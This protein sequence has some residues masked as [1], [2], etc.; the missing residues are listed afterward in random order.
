MRTFLA[1]LTITLGIITIHAQTYTVP[2]DPTN[3]MIIPPPSQAWQ[4]AKYGEYPVNRSTGVPAIS[5]PIHEIKVGPLSIPIGLNYHA[6]GIKVDEKASWV[7]LGWNLSAGGMISRVV[8]GHP[9]EHENG[10][11]NRE[12]PGS[13]DP[14]TIDDYEDLAR[15]NEGFYDTEPDIF[16]YNFN[17][18]SGRFFYKDVNTIITQPSSDLLIEYELAEI[19]GICAFTITTPDGIIYDF[20]LSETVTYEP[21]ID[22]FFTAGQDSWTASSVWYLTKI[23]SLITGESI[24]FTYDPLSVT[25]S[26]PFPVQSRTIKLIPGSP[27]SITDYGLDDELTYPNAYSGLRYLKEIQYSNGKVVFNSDSYRGNYDSK[28]PRLTSIDIYGFENELKRTFKLDNDQFFTSSGGSSSR[29][30]YRL[31]LDAVWMESSSINQDRTYAFTYLTSGAQALPPRYDT[32]QDY[33]GYHNGEP[34]QSLIPETPYPSYGFTFGSGNDLSSSEEH[35]K[36]GILEKITYPTKGYTLFDFEAN[37]IREDNSNVTVGGLRVKSIKNYNATGELATQKHFIYEDV[38]ATGESSGVYNAP[39]TPNPYTYL[40]SVEIR[41]KELDSNDQCD[42]FTDTYVSV[43]AKPKNMLGFPSGDLVT[44]KYVTVIHEESQSEYGKSVYEYDTYADDIIWNRSPYTI[45]RSELRG[46]LKNETHFDDNGDEVRSIGYDYTTTEVESIKG[47]KIGKIFDFPLGTDCWV[48]SF[49]CSCTE[50]TRLNSVLGMYLHNSYWERSYWK[51]LDSKTEVVYGTNGETT[52]TITEYSYDGTGHQ[53]LTSQSIT[54]SDGR[55]SKLKNKYPLDYAEGSRSAILNSMIL[56]NY[57]APSIEQIFSLDGKVLQA[58][59]TQY[60]HDPSN[61]L[62]L[63]FKQYT[64]ETDTPISS[65][66]ESSDGSSFSSYE[67]WGTYK[68]F[69]FK[70]NL[71]S[72]SLTDNIST[73]YIWGYNNS[74]PVAK[75]SNAEI[76]YTGETNKQVSTQNYSDVTSWTNLG[77]SL[78]LDRDQSISITISVTFEEEGEGDDV[79]CGVRLKHPDGTTDVFSDTYEPGEYNINSQVLPAGSYQYQYTT[80]TGAS[81][82]TKLKVITEYEY[83]KEEY[84][85]VYESFEESDNASTDY[86]K[87]GNKSFFGEYILSVNTDPGNYTLTYWKKASTSDPWLFYE[88]DLVNPTSYTIAGSGQYTDEIRLY[89]K[90]A[91]MET[92]TYDPL[93]GMKSHTDLNNQTT[94]YDYDD[95]GRLKLVRDTDGNILKEYEYNYAQ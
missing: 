44:Y 57:I 59:A 24:L 9:D 35:M 19:G 21:K 22:N 54:N 84:S 56:E 87:T 63:P 55:I 1:L 81:D 68:G 82:V 18:Y 71:V 83:P 58:N 38:N 34:N 41:S 91:Q 52:T 46:Q 75:I 90:G 13:I 29:F 31:K 92:Y 95:F 17:G 40:N 32:S 53:Q 27:N 73:S 64:L 30:N 4:F 80:N 42:L 70:G 23:E 16:Q 69:D 76:N 33:W 2:K 61:D 20:D 88:V 26:E 8:K 28:E 11:L 72:Y 3:E 36:A 65:F 86:A 12:I 89:P 85:F 67:L 6:G 37:T 74:L 79:S 43:T 78:E 15:M 25:D 47:Y 48:I 39:F 7:G 5:I 50:S 14:Q 60:Q 62:V 93:V 51:H 10:H 77:T 49:L 94:Y 66:V 45:D